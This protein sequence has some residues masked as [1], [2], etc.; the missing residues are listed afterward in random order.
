V[1]QTNN[2]KPHFQG[3]SPSDSSVL[4]SEVPIAS[5]F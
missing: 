3:D 2:S 4:V 5:E 1:Q